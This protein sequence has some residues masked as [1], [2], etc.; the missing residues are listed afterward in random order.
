MLTKELLNSLEPGTV[1]AAGPDNNQILSDFTPIRWIAVKRPNDTWGIYYGEIRTPESEI[2]K[3][4][5]KVYD[6]EIIKKLVP[7]DEEALLMYPR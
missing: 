1:I 6:T 4:G 3:N 7:C 5:D 2:L